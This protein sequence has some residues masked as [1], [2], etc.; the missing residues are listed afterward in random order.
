[1]RGKKTIITCACGC[2]I[3]KAVRTADVKRGWG[4][5][6]SKSHKQ[7]HQEERKKIWKTLQ[8]KN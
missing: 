2:G 1:M 5:Y 8:R 6:L 7:A 4:K 3:T